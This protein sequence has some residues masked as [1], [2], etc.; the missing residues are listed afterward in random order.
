[1]SDDGD[2]RGRAVQLQELVGKRAG[3][4]F[5]SPKTAAHRAGQADGE[6]ARAVRLLNLR[7]QWLASRSSKRRQE[8]D[9][10]DLEARAL[11]AGDKLLDDRDG[12]PGPAPL[13]ASGCRS[14]AAA[15]NETRAIGEAKYGNRKSHHERDHEGRCEEIAW[16]PAHR[17]GPFP[18]ARR[19]ATVSAAATDDDGSAG[20]LHLLL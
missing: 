19:M 5:R 13:A 2:A 1:M 15:A 18:D 11:K 4:I 12:A 16:S 6:R 3:D 14:V 17:L 9:R 8:R 10:A 20:V 7:L